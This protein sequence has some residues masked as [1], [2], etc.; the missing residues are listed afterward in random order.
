MQN[1]VHNLTKVY[2]IKTKFTLTVQLKM[3]Q[4]L[5]KRGGDKWQDEV[6]KHS[7]DGR[8]LLALAVLYFSANHLGAKDFDH[9]SKHTNC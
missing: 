8:T 2:C 6:N 4:P 9:L 5:G 7:G 1:E 3:W